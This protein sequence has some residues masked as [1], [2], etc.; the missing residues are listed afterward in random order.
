MDR[1]RL[2]GQSGEHRVGDEAARANDARVA[3][4]KEY[5]KLQD[6]DRA[7]VMLAINEQK[8]VVGWALTLLIT[9]KGSKD[10][11]LDGWYLMGVMVHPQFRRQGI[12]QQLTRRRIK[13]LESRTRKVRYF[14]QADNDIAR[15]LHDKFEFKAVCMVDSIAG[16][17][18]GTNE[19]MVF[20]LD[21]RKRKRTPS[22]QPPI[23]RNTARPKSN[24]HH[25]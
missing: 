18:F 15:G 6:E 24:R 16:I 21:L 2:A 25:H 11:S 3:K 19:R 7:L 4:L 5:I 23:T 13:W 10:R 9:S 20:E 22:S 17:S 8:K 1:V 12:G 14:T